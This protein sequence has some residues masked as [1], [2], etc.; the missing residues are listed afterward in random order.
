MVNNLS[1]KILILLLNFLCGIFQAN[2]QSNSTVR[3]MTGTM[4]IS[5]I[6]TVKEGPLVLDSMNYINSFNETYTVSRL[7][8]YISN[9]ALN[10]SQHGFT[11]PDSYHLIDAADSSSLNF[12]FDAAA[13]T[14]SS[15]SFMVGVDSIKNVSGAQSG[16]LD[17]SRGM[18]WTWNSGYVMFKL[19]GSSPVSS[20]F[21]HRIE[22]HIGGFEGP[23]NVVQL[24]TIPLPAHFKLDAGRSSEIIIMADL[25][26][27]WQ[28]AND[29]KIA[30][31]AVTMAPGVLS[32]KIAD[33]YNRMF[34]IKEV[35]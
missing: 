22:Y 19:E 13:N 4:N 18:F 9:I 31:T 23:M 29:L 7:K 6:N 14:Y 15:I 1:P 33:N 10:N 28:G 3:A 21:N 25:N 20:I 12:S 27:L 16:A 5:F 11:E 34:S 35:K 24:I 26:K 17:P 2:A 32:K 30:E 8:Y